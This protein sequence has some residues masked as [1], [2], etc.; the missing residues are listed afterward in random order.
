MGLSE[1]GKGTVFKLYFP[2]VASAAVPQTAPETR[3]P[4]GGGEI[5]LLVED[6]EAVRKLTLRMLQQL[7]YQVLTA[8]N[9]QKGIE[10]A[11][12]HSGNID[13]LLTDVV[14]PNMS[15]KQLA[16]AVLVVHPETSVIF[17]SGYTENTV[18]HHGVLNPGVEFLPK[19][20][21]RE[22]LANKLREVLGAKGRMGKAED[23]S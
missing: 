8:P 14:M 17:I 1:A 10:T 6:E 22:T 11:Q 16:D 7:G 23:P 2:T 21:S 19:P 13:C 18:V 15:G 12:G 4:A 5:I 9:G 20:F 3:I